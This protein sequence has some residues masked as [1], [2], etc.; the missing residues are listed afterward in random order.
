MSKLFRVHFSG[1]VA[2][3]RRIGDILLIGNL[4]STE[5]CLSKG[6][7]YSYRTMPTPINLIYGLSYGTIHYGALREYPDFW[8]YSSLLKNGSYIFDN[9][10]MSDYRR[11]LLRYMKEYL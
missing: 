9:Y 7:L 4:L 8:E 2:K 6:I 10:T 1:T 5:F 3:E 11:F